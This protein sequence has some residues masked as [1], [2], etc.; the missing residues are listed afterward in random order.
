MDWERLAAQLLGLPVPLTTHHLIFAP[1]IVKDTVCIPSL[2]TALPE[3]GGWTTAADTYA[4]FANVWT[5]RE[6][7]CVTVPSLNLCRLLSVGHKNVII[8]G[9]IIRLRVFFF[10]S[11]TEQYYISQRCLN[12]VYPVG[13]FI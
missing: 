13:D 7:V 2:S 10:H 11:C 12:F 4:M 9:T 3:I 1:G 8:Q 5:E 6:T